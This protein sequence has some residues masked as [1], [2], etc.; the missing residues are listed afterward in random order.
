MSTD[1]HIVAP[2]DGEQ[3]L[4]LGGHVNIKIPSEATGGAF[5][6]VEHVIPPNGGPPPHTHVETELL[7]VLSGT[8]EVVVG[9]TRT[10]VGSGTVIHVPR[11]TVHTT[12]NV[13]DSAGRQLSIYLPGGGEGFF[14]EAGTPVVSGQVLP[15]FAQPANLEGV[16]MGL[17]MATAARYGIQIQVGAGPAT[18]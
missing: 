16:D 12:R 14:R 11:G 9:P 6:V 13:G 17:L 8:F 2:T 18:P 15:D 1:H 10:T 3:L 5:A 7:Y 4:N